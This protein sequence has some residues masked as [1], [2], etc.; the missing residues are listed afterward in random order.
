MSANKIDRI[1]NL[2]TGALSKNIRILNLSDNQIQKMEGLDGMERLQV[3]KLSQNMI[4]EV[5]NYLDLSSLVHF[6]I[7]NNCL[8]QLDM[9]DARNYM[10]EL[11]QLYLNSN[12]LSNNENNRKILSELGKHLKVLKFILK[13]HEQEFSDTD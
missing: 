13:D 7:S 1:I 5:D 3:L 10:P 9:K 11:N 8:T 2:N 12:P 4:K 6:D